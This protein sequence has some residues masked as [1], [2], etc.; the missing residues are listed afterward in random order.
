MSSP[1]PFLDSTARSRVA[2]RLLPFLF[3]LYIT[4]YL[5]R[6]NVGYAAL[7]MTHDL[8]LSDAVF[9]TAAGVFFIGYLSLQIPGALLVERWSARL[10][11]AG[12]LIAWG[13]LTVLTA[14]VQ[15][16]RQLYGAR[17]ILGMA[18]AG[19]FPGVIV[20]LSHWFIYQDRS[21]A[22]ARFMAAIPISF[23]IGSPLAGRLL[24]VH[25]LGMAGWR[26]LFVVEGI[27]AVLLGLITS[28]WLPDRPADAQWLSPHEREWLQGRLE[29]EKRAK[30]GV[31]HYGVLR[32]L[33]HPPVL[34]LTTSLL[35]S[36]TAGY[37]FVFFFPTMLKRLSGWTDFRVGVVGTLP[38]IA[39]FIGMQIA[40]WSSDRH[41]ERRWHFAATQLICLSG[42]A[43]LL[44]APHSLPLALIAFTLI[45]TGI[46]SSYPCF[47]ALPS[48]LLN[49]AAAA[50][51][52]GFINSFA[53]IGGYIGPWV[54]GKLSGRTGS[55][56]A[57]FWFMLVSYAI[58]TLVVL[59]CPREAVTSE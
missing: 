32:A 25:W 37:A 38:Y 53:S 6:A 11:L 14:L 41:R 2:R 29:A 51:A 9:G 10:W 7:R 40:G 39:G 1:V 26:W 46:T 31:Q 19:F 43:L 18:E 55:F 17:F 36:Y 57:G 21:K 3:L 42:A 20:Y 58:A 28:F 4:N 33:R 49:D 59:L 35:F 13:G 52:I 50:A 48:S 45:G 12:T 16:P 34:L 15:T 8:G 44:L 5:D 22:V 47:W 23:V 56:G 24:Q 30:A 27:P 54:F